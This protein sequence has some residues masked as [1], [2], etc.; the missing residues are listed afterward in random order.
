[1]DWSR[2]VRQAPI[3]VGLTRIR[4]IRQIGPSL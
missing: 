1:V 2:L 3:G 4:S